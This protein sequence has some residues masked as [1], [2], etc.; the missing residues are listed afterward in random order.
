MQKSLEIVG[1]TISWML[2]FLK[3]GVCRVGRGPRQAN[4]M[5]TCRPGQGGV[6]RMGYREEVIT[7]ISS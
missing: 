2:S 7:M 1:F 6:M 4:S 3:M 5:G